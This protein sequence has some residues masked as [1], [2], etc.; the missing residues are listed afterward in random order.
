MLLLLLLEGWL[1][2]KRLL[3]GWLLVWRLVRRL[4]LRVPSLLKVSRSGRLDLSSLVLGP[5][6]RL[7]SLGLCL[8]SLHNLSLSRLVCEP[9]VHRCAR[10]IVR[11]PT[12]EDLG[13]EW[14]WRHLR[15]VGRRHVSRWLRIRR[16]LRRHLRH[17][18][19][20]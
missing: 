14:C 18:W 4:H 11:V 9:V 10:C 8:G 6:L 16:H 13:L 5:G 20:L 7:G 15:H 2:V 3:E 17:L 1:L 19:Q 12:A